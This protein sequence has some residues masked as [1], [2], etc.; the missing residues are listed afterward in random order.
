MGTSQ[1]QT[2]YI[3]S[4]TQVFGKT[5]AGYGLDVFQ[6][7]AGDTSRQEGQSSWP[8]KAIS[9]M[10]LTLH[11]TAV[12]VPV[13]AIF[14]HSIDH[15]NGFTGFEISVFVTFSGCR[16]EPFFSI[17]HL[18]QMT[19]HGPEVVM[20]IWVSFHKIVQV[21]DSVLEFVISLREINHLQ[22]AL[23]FWE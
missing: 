12:M 17:Q 14:Q 16:I 13:E 4:Q 9:L 11:D 2:L 5:T 8:G 3:D 19:T 18:E 15:A 10:N 7:Y 1:R 23:Q 22:L 20:R 21:A 6:E